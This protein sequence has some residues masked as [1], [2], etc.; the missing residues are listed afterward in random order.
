M[1]RRGRIVFLGLLA[2]GVIAAGAAASIFTA[3]PPV[4]ASGPSPFASCTNIGPGTPGAVN[5]VNAEVEPW[6]DVNP[7]DPKNIIGVW[8]QDRW[9]D[10]GARGLVAGVTHD[11]G[12]NWARTWAPFTYC[13]GGNASNGGDFERASD[14]WVTFSPNGT[15]YQI[16][17]AF[18]GLDLTNAVTVSRSVDGGD[19]WSPLTT[20]IRD[21]GERDSSWAFNDKESITAD[22]LDSNLVYAVWDRLVSPNNKSKASLQ[23]LLNSKTFRGPTWF[24]R[25]TNGGASWEPARVISDPGSHNQTIGNQIDVLPDGTL[26]DLFTEFVEHKN[27][28]GIRG[29]HFA[30][31]RSSDK[32]VTWSKPIIVAEDTSGGVRDPD[33]G[34]PLRVG[35]II[36]DI[37][38]NRHPGTLGYGNAY[39]VWEGRSSPSSTNDD[40]ILL[41][42]STDGGSTWSDPIKVN[43]TP[44]GAAAFTPAVHVSADGTVG[45]T[46]YDL[47]NN[48]PSPAALPTD[49]WLVHSH[50]GGLTFGDEVRLTTASFDTTTA[51]VAGGYF[52]GDYEG[53]SSVG[54]LFTPLFVA[55]NSGDTANRTDAFFTTAGP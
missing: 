50:D 32:G 29:I 16:A 54:N 18:N 4:A 43:Q 22:P 13:S 55:A 5:Y 11:G 2:A 26:L 10:G 47:R 51:P 3:T 28:H 40:A 37:A 52:L 23:G 17:I 25:T 39:V 7:R 31:I 20:L 53:L 21:S 27:A 14:P 1:L 30:V 42:R 24:A 44:N 46:Y 33:T 48:T 41:S 45:V 34:A 15:A 6:V 12:L 36:P 8:Q 9:S 35:D 19:S 49:Y 38:V